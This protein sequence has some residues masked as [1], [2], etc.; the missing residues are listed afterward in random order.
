M[1]KLAQTKLQLREFET[2]LT[3]T[4]IGEEVIKLTTERKSTFTIKR[5]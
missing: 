2:K 1:A 4:H 3:I 5:F